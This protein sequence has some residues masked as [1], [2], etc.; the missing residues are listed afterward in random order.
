MLVQARE[1]DIYD[2]LLKSELTAYLTDCDEAFDVV[3]SADTLVYFGPLDAVAVAAEQALRPGGR[4]VFTV[5]ELV[6]GTGYS[7]AASGRYQHAREYVSAVL[8]DAGFHPEIVPAELRLEGGEPV[9]GLVALGGKA[10]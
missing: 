6:D 2:E 10:T 4:L 9:P 7:L 1:R 8:A 3:V 5:E